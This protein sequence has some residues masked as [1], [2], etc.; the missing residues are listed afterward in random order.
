MGSLFYVN[1]EYVEI[2]SFL[3]SLE[4]NKKSTVYSFDLNG[5]DIYDSNIEFPAIILLG[6]ESNGVRKELDAVID[7]KLRIPINQEIDSLNVSVSQAIALAE[8]NRVLKQ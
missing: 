6:N 5:E 4:S 1:I 2:V 8:F 7:K 3:T